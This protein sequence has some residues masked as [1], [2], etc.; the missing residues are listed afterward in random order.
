MV[1]SIQE[2]ATFTLVEHFCPGS[3]NGWEKEKTTRRRQEGKE[4]AK[5]EV[6]FDRVKAYKVPK[7]H[8]ASCKAAITW[9]TVVFYLVK[10]KPLLLRVVSC[11]LLTSQCCIPREI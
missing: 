2:S 3:G 4:K 6:V 5:T 1:P 10:L 9:H 8:T 7:Y 11:V